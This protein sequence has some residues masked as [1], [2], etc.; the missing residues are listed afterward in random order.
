LQRQLVGSG[1]LPV[2]RAFSRARMPCLGERDRQWRFSRV[3]L[4]PEVE[5]R[6]FNRN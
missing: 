5:L 2:Q 6:R 4:T 1:F 3:V